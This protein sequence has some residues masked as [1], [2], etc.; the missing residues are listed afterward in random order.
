MHLPLRWSHSDDQ[1]L[2]LFCNPG[3]KKK[4]AFVCMVVGTVV[5]RMEAY[6][7]S[8]II[9]VI[10]GEVNWTAKITT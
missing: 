5:R 1:N 8:K 10:H 7:K 4:L 2:N 9:P 3:E 6:L